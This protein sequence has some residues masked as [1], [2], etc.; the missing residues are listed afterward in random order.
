MNKISKLKI[1]GMATFNGVLLKSS[2]KQVVTSQ[3]NDNI[4]SEVTE[5]KSNRI[6]SSIPIIRGIVGLYTSIKSGIPYIVE[7][8]ENI[9]NDI[10]ND[11]NDKITV[12]K[13]EIIISFII[14]IIIFSLIWVSVPMFISL[15]LPN[16]DLR[17]LVQ[18]LLK[19]VMFSIYISTIK[20]IS[21]LHGLFEYHAA[22][23][24]AVNYY[25]N[26]VKEVEDIKSILDLDL[27]KVASYSRFHRRCGSN[28]IMYL[29]FLSLILTAIVP[30]INIINKIIIEILTFP[31]LI[32]LAYES[33][34]LFTLLPKKFDFV[35]LPFMYVQNITTKKPSRAKLLIGVTSLLEIT[36]KH[37][38]IEKYIKQYI[39][40]YLKN[41]EVNQNDIL[42]L[43]SY[44]LNI[45]KD[46][47]YINL[48]SNH[49]SIAQQIKIKDILDRYYINYEPLQYITQ[50][51]PFYN[52]EY[53]V[54]KDVLIPRADSE[55]LVE[56][57]I[58]YIDA[59]NL[60]NGIDMCSGSGALG[61]S[62]SKNSNIDTMILVDVSDKALIIANKNIEKN[63]MNIKCTSIK[64]NLFESILPNNTKYDIIVTNPPYIKAEELI[65]L[66]NYVQKEP[67]LALNGGKSGLDFYERIFKEA[68]D[69][70]VN[71]GYI[72]LEIGYEQKQDIIN[73]ISNYPEYE[74]IEC[75]QDLG[76]KDRVIVCHFHQ[77]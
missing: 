67:M 16:T 2:T 7:S 70:L 42:R 56:A 22:E 52:E 40:K 44:A 73:L 12:G 47:L 76:L 13:F 27:D 5:T 4:I 51:Q 31:I 77:I 43:V 63:S 9:V 69:V 15:L 65:N 41:Y 48:K 74:Y 68:K 10:V 75:I 36:T 21:Y 62:I 59:N 66:S 29:L 28:F 61:I 71:N 60:K 19:L 20:K 49:I 25:E 58:K 34:N 23:H 50:I 54:N 18:I 6:I 55:I 3:I 8:A 30:S 35:L 33:L 26:N 57:A 14:S 53:I 64:S 39:N 24:T 1:G 11:K 38:S 37:I 45:D 32:G 72:I 46:S 17:F